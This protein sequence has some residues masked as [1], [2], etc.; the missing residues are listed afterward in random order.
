MITKREYEHVWRECR[1][2]ENSSTGL[3]VCFDN[4]FI[5]DGDGFR[6]VFW[7][8]IGQEPWPWKMLASR[9]ETQSA[10]PQEAFDKAIALRQQREG[11]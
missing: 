9:E 8:E 10:T 5:K 3:S 11:E 6:K 4:A 7:V 2:E 1:R